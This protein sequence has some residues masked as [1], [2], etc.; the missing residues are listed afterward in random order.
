MRV[1]LGILGMVEA[2]Q[3]DPRECLVRILFEK[4]PLELGEWCPGMIVCIVYLLVLK[5]GVCGSECGV[6]LE[7]YMG[8]AVRH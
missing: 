7:A 1:S 8:N 5:G 4:L 2:V 3:R 6:A